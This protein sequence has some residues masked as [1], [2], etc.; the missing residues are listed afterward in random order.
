VG[1]GLA[2]TETS[3]DDIGSLESSSSSSPS[4]FPLASALSFGFSSS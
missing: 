2:M 1:G 3:L 4:R